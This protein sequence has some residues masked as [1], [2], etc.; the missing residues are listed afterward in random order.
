MKLNK[1][2]V[3]LRLFSLSSKIPIA[4]PSS[5]FDSKNENIAQQLN[6]YSEQPGM[7]SSKRKSLF[8]G[9]L[10]IWADLAQSL[11]SPVSGDGSTLIA[12]ITARALLLADD[13]YVDDGL[14]LHCRPSR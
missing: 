7:N 14:S 2:K 4:L 8:V 5:L 6:R 12:D 1:L 9:A 13:V 3:N 11:C 10:L